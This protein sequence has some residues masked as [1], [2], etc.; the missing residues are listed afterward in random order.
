MAASA[1]ERTVAAVAATRTTGW[2]HLDDFGHRQGGIESEVAPLS[3]GRDRDDEDAAQALPR[4]TRGCLR[5]RANP[6]PRAT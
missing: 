2:S 4:N 5:V 1:H 6:G 3:I